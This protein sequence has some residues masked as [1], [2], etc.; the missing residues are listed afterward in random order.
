MRRILKRVLV[1]DPS[2]RPIAQ[3]VERFQDNGSDRVVHIAHRTLIRCQGCQH[4]VED[5][6]DLRGR[7]DYCRTRGCCIH[8]ETRCQGCSRRLCWACRRGFA[9]QT[10]MTL[11]AV[12]LVKMQRRQALLDYEM[13]AQAAFQRRLLAQ[14]ERIRVQGL[15]AQAARTR[16]M[17]FL[18][19]ARLRTTSQLQAARIRQ[20]GQIA[21]MREMNRLRLTLAKLIYHGRYR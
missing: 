4:L 3:N 9:G 6:N 15:R 5:A 12:C 20:V 1:R 7:C 14:R 21:T 11:C 18:H 13:R 2:G 10:L 17:G 16:A 8:C 19:A